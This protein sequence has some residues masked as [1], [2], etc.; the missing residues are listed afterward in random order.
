MIYNSKEEVGLSSDNLSIQLLF[1]IC[2]GTALTL[3]S[4][5]LKQLL[6]GLAS[7]ILVLVSPTVRSVSRDDPR[8]VAKARVSVC[9]STKRNETRNSRL[10]L[11]V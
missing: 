1:A 9:S 11:I 5:T 2:A 10:K 7:C 8:P 4:V 6:M 3:F